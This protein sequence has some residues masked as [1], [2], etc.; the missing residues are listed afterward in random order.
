MYRGADASIHP[1]ISG[2]SQMPDGNFVLTLTAQPA[3]NYTLLASTNINLPSAQW[4]VISTGQVPVG[5][6]ML[7]DLAATNFPSRFYR[8]ITTQSK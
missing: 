2:L 1:V 8:L 5:P 3:Q 4:P 7:T 6:F